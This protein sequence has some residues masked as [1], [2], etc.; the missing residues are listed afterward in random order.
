MQL[1]GKRPFISLFS[2]YPHLA[3]DPLRVQVD[4][5]DFYPDAARP[6]DEAEGPLP[7]A[8][9]PLLEDFDAGHG[10]RPAEPPPDPWDL[11]GGPHAVR[12]PPAEHV[13]LH[14][15]PHGSARPDP[16]SYSHGGGGGSPEHLQL[17]LHQ[18]IVRP[19]HITVD[20][21]D[22]GDPVDLRLLQGNIL[23]DHDIVVRDNDV[24]TGGSGAPFPVHHID[25][26]DDLASMAKAQVPASFAAPDHTPEQVVATLKAHASG[27]PSQTLVEGVTVDG[28]AVGSGT[29][30]PP[31]PTLLVPPSPTDHHAD[32][33]VTHTGGNS[34]VNFAELI[35]ARGPVGTLVVMGDSYK[36]DAIIQTNVLVDHSAVV[37]TADTAIVQTGD[38]AAN[39]VAEFVATLDGNPYQMGFFGGLHWHVDRLNGDFYDV[40]MVTQFNDMRDNDWVQQTAS[41]HYKF[42]ATGDNALGNQLLWL[43]DGKQ[44]DLVIVN[45]NYYAANWI[46]QTNILLNSDYVELKAGPDGAGQETVVSTGANW[47]LNTA[48]IADYSG[49]AHPLSPEMQHV[50]DALQSGEETLD[51]S[52]G[53]AVAGD[54]SLTLNVLFITGNYY[55]VNVLNQTNVVG[56]TGP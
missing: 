38:N 36:S 14:D 13:T 54:G 46:F 8:L 37:G 22:G 7:P 3:V 12:P 17:R 29:P 16:V 40:K 21:R 53:L 39:N 6:T 24:V 55:D 43:Q 28:H 18:L 4:Y 15:V 41:D 47:L 23:S 51:P 49:D 9:P 30:P 33:A 44:Y 10:P 34:V 25:N 11:F 42:T 5:D 31:D 32:V 35:D 56:D 19:L 26:I 50:V 45:G 27:S 20:Y 1:D 52:L 48:R 2:G